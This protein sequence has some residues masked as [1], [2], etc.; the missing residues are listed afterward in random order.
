MAQFMAEIEGNKGRVHRLG[1]KNSGAMGHVRGWN[2]GARVEVSHEDGRD[3]VRVYR[4]S[5]SS[6]RGESAMIA[7]FNGDT[8]KGAE[9]CPAS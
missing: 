5:G 3:V 4:T 1:S 6:A 9:V 7:E 8:A 2:V